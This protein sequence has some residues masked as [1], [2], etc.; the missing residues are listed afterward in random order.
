MNRSKD[1]FLVAGILVTSALA[2]CDSDRSLGPAERISP[3]RVPS[4]ATRTVIDVS[5]GSEYGIDFTG[6][7]LWDNDP[8]IRQVR[9]RRA[10]ELMSAAGVRFARVTAYWYLLQQGGDNTF[11]P[12]EVARLRD[13]IQALIATGITP[14]ITLEATAC[15][16]RSTAFPCDNTQVYSPPDNEAHWQAWTTYVQQ[17][18]QEFPEVHYWGIW[19]EPNSAFLLPNGGDRL[20]AYKQLVERAAPTIHA[21]GGIVIGLDLGDSSD[22]SNGLTREQWLTNFLSTHGSYIDVVAVHLYGDLTSSDFARDMQT[23]SNLLSG[24]PWYLW[25][26]EV[27]IG[28]GRATDQE[29]AAHLTT[30]YQTMNGMVGSRWSKTFYFNSGTFILP[31][32]NW[33]IVRDLGTT[34]QTG[35]P[36]YYSLK[37]MTPGP[38][39]AYLQGPVDAYASPNCHLQYIV[40]ASKGA[41]GYTYSGWET[42]GTVLSQ[43]S[44]WMTVAFP[45]AGTHY[46]RVTVTDGLGTQVVAAMEDIQ[47][48]ASGTDCN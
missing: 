18:M 21:A 11:A 48:S 9:L 31:D 5:P 22:P 3:M 13:G 47:A 23:Y 39:E 37:A 1:V 2:A 24:G 41:G 12:W 4:R 25:L 26:T 17:M 35:R 44:E 38:L 20:G 14:Y 34:S 30:V 46:V 16:A 8:T 29:Q 36:A 10:A 15:F 45:V 32:T 40:H 27:A 33:G 42:D 6:N 43:N 19:N 28:G 7:Y